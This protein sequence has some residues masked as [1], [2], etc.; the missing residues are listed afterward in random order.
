MAEGAAE[1]LTALEKGGG[2][3]GWTVGERMAVSVGL[4]DD[5][6]LS[7]RAARRRD[8]WWF[9]RSLREGCVPQCRTNERNEG[10]GKVK[11][12]GAPDAAGRE[13]SCDG[14]KCQ[15][16]AAL[17]SCLDRRRRG[18]IA[19]ARPTHYQLYLAPPKF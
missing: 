5:V 2:S 9:R 18:I 6:G 15:L 13:G 19:P 7:G 10:R 16:N 3:D 17:P 14:C 1:G 12:K 11:C 4:E 8:N